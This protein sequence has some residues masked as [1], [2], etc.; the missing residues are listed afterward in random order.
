MVPPAAPRRPA[1]ADV[2]DKRRVG[3][4]VDGDRLLHESIKQLATVPGRSAVEPERE[5]VE[6]VIEMGAAHGALMRAEQPTFQERHDPV[7][8]RQQFGRRFLPPL[9]KRDAM[10]I[11]MLSPAGRR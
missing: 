10:S 5:L 9:Q 6:V 2:L 7:H 3:C 1:R 4:R 11:A 8:V